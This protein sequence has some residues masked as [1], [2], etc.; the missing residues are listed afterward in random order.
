MIKVINGFENYLYKHKGTI[1]KPIDKP[2]KDKSFK[3]VL[4]EE[5]NRQQQKTFYFFK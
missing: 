5:K 3:E 2:I 1:I 4:N